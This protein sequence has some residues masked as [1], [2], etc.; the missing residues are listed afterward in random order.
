MRKGKIK[1]MVRSAAL[2]VWSAGVSPAFFMEAYADNAVFTETLQKNVRNGHV[3]YKAMCKDPALSTYI[4][5][6]SRTAP[7]GSKESQLAFWINAYNAYTLKVICDHYPVKSINE[8]HRGGL[9]IGTLTK[10]TIWDKKLAV[11]NGEPLTLNHI[12]HE[13]IRKQFHEPR[14]HFALVCASVSCPALRPEA[15]EATKLNEQL[16]DQGRIFFAD[17]GKNSFDVPNKIAHLSKILDWYS[18]DF[19]KTKQDVLLFASRFVA[20]PIAS[21]IRKDP[22]KWKIEYTDYNWDLNE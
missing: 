5:Q 12:E 10:G 11:V 4:T 17:S 13:V 20:E 2:I 1:N 22:G 7:E 14:A 16:E 21:E 6:L 9:I 3:N 18:G 19:G 8:L 15:Y